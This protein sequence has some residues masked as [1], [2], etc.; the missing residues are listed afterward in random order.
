MSGPNT[1]PRRQP[2]GVGICL[3]VDF[4]TDAS[5]I[6]RVSVCRAQSTEQGRSYPGSTLPLPPFPF[7]LFILFLPPALF[8]PSSEFRSFSRPP[9]LHF[10]FSRPPRPF[11]CFFLI[12]FT[13]R[14]L[15]HV[16]LSRADQKSS[17]QPGCVH[18]NM[19]LF[20]WALRL[21]PL[22]PSEDM[23]DALELAVSC[24]ML[25]RGS[26]SDSGNRSGCMLP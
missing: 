7:Y 15:N 22:L 2:Q 12:I 14:P 1:L 3:I 26:G 8:R 10:F 13:T 17:D 5:C 25:V 18:A 20:K 23:T 6:F 19:D 11:L 21:W 9:P 4:R 24:R 16:V